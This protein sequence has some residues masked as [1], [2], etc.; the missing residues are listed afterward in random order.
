[1]PFTQNPLHP[2]HQ[3]GVSIEIDEPDA[4]EVIFELHPFDD[5]DIEQPLKLKGSIK[6]A[7]LSD[8]LG[9]GDMI[10]ERIQ[11]LQ[12][13]YNKFS[14]SSTYL[15]RLSGLY[16]IVNQPDMSHHYLEKALEVAGSDPYLK[17]RLGNALL[18]KGDMAGAQAI[19][20]Q[21]SDEH[22]IDALVKLAYLTTISGNV[23]E[24]T[25]LVTEALSRNPIHYG[26]RMLF[27]CLCLY[28]KNYEFAVRHFKEAQIEKPYSSTACVN[29]AAA[30]CCLGDFDSALKSLNKAVAIDPLNENAVLFLA[31]LSRELRKDELA[32]K[33]LKTFI[34]YNN[35]SGRGWERLA[36]ASYYIEDYK[37]AFQALKSQGDIG[38]FTPEIWNNLGLISWRMGDK[39]KSATFFKNA[40]K[41]AESNGEDK[42][43]YEVNYS[44]LLIEMKR[45]EEILGLNADCNAL[46]LREES[47]SFGD[48][49]LQRVISLEALN[50][51]EQ[52]YSDADSYLLEYKD[53]T[54]IRLKLLLHMNYYTTV[55]EVDKEK[56]I[57]L[58]DEIFSFISSSNVTIDK[59]LKG[60]AYN[61]VMFAF[62]EF[63]CLDKAMKVR[64]YLSQFVHI[65]PYATATLGLLHLKCGH[66][67]RG[68]ELYEE[69]IGL[70]VDSK[71]KKRIRQRM[72]LELGLF[73]LKAGDKKAAYSFFQKAKNQKLGYPY[74]TAR[75][76][77]L[78][79]SVSAR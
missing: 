30:Y 26:A 56:S 48:A 25:K 2:L 44:W 75:A 46:R 32:I 62:L 7:H 20:S 58:A 59:E 10:S 61:S 21:L 74:I 69:G 29:L 37:L 11:S 39:D 45:Y 15:N 68:K 71:I 5:L 51:F 28:Q 76:K 66:Y 72:F 6:K 24:A 65:S 63:D 41:K 35:D 38:E 42:L 43:F 67:K 1:M 4:T 53:D 64:D 9:S 31:D 16:D 22:D 60:R 23:S 12:E 73:H 54:L 3:L 18:D 47:K 33:S 17:H 52:A 8:L 36:R 40:I 77:K 19:F 70:A 13:K 14:D 34:E 49:V 50:K 27:G 57:K 79:A 55:I 78:A